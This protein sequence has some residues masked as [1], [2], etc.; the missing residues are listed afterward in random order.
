MKKRSAVAVGCFLVV[1]ALAGLTG[2]G[3]GGDSP[4]ILFPVLPP[5]TTIS[6]TIDVTG[7]DPVVIIISGGLTVRDNSNAI[8]GTPVIILEAIVNNSC[9]YTVDIPTPTMGNQTVYFKAMGGKAT[10]SSKTI[11]RNQTGTV[12]R[13]DASVT[14]Y[15]YPQFAVA[16]PIASFTLNNNDAS[17]NIGLVNWNR[18]AITISGSISDFSA[19]GSFLSIWASTSSPFDN[20]LGN[21]YGT[22]ME[23]SNNGSY[24]INIE[25]PSGLPKTIYLYTFQASGMLTGSYIPLGSVIIPAGTTAG[26]T[27]PCNLIVPY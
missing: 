1:W 13:P 8:L 2:C 6:G 10:L 21:V 15:L 5:T 18:S 19:L 26:T 16:S 22:A 25:V 7:L 27:I 11:L 24:Y 3:R 20:N 9:P 4:G 23:S 14:V 12:F 17:K